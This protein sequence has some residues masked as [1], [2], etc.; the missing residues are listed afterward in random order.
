METIVDTWTTRSTREIANCRVF[1]VR[2][3]TSVRVHDGEL[4]TF[5][6]VASPDWVNVVAITEDH[7]AV[8]I[9]QF[10]H[11]TGTVVTEIP[12]GMIDKGEMPENAAARELLEETG[13]TPGRLIH[14]GTSFPN[15]AIQDNTI[16][17]FLA[18]NCKKTQSASFDDYESINTRLVPLHELE[19]LVHNG[20]I[21]HSLAVTALYFA[22][23]YL[24]DENIIT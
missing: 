20:E 6:V 13:Y 11:G 16:H 23:R 10:R 14:L 5:F 12:G 21:E 2:E 19:A 17:H 15:P 3:D 22:N 9:E 8:L 7:M 4:S 1:R 18:L 24:R